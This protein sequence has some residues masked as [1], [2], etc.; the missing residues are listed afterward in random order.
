MRTSPSARAR[1]TA[2]LIGLGG[3]ALASGSAHA[4]GETATRGDDESTCLALVAYAEAAGEGA[5]GMAAVIRVIR[6][7]VADERF[8]DDACSV[9][10]QP[11]QFQPVGEQPRLRAALE[12]PGRADPVHALGGPAAV[13]PVVLRSAF[14]LARTGRPASEMQDATAG[15]LYFVNPAYMDPQHCPWFATLK[16]TAQ[17]GQHVFMTHYGPDEPSR[18]A[19]IDCK[20]AGKGRMVKADA[21]SRRPS[22]ALQPSRTLLSSDVGDGLSSLSSSVQTR[23][24]SRVDGRIGTQL[25]R[26]GMR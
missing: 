22:L 18:G 20:E 8:P 14:K 11:G 23:I 5:A 9:V 1:T 25:G 10:L 13:D 15:A 26:P 17:V 6:N 7:R 21:G 19:A 4:T 16:L 3:L 12:S 24:S 2:V